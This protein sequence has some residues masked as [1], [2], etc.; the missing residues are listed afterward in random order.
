MYQEKYFLTN[1]GVERDIVVLVV[2]DFYNHQIDCIH[3]VL[4]GAS[5]ARIRLYLLIDKESVRQN[6]DRLANGAVGT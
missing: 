3:Q 1:Q 5:R 6:A 2:K 4:I